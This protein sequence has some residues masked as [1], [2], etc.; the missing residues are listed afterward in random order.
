MKKLTLIVAV[1]TGLNACTPSHQ[2]MTGQGFYAENNI[3]KYQLNV[4]TEKG[5]VKDLGFFSVANGGCGFYT[6]EAADNGV[7]VPAVKEKLRQ[8][9]GNVADG[10]LTKEAVGIDLLLGL[11]IVPG[12]LAC[13]NWTIT[14]NAFLVSDMPK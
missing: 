13:S 6:R 5:N 10:I 4:L 7:V 11:F 9:G 12:L 8:L 2:Y 14:G 3:N 1:L